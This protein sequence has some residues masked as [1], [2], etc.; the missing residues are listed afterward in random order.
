MKLE[1]FLKTGLRNRRIYEPGITLY[2][3]RS[4]RSGID[5]D[6]ATMDADEPGQGALTRF[7]DKYEKR[8]SFFVE[9]IHNPRLASY[10][11]RRGYFRVPYTHDVHMVNRESVYLAYRDAY[12]KMLRTITGR[13]APSLLEEF[14]SR[15]RL[16]G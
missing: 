16:G 11:E 2:I 13:A 14:A 8:F 5:I 4:I 6:L 3:R 1:E 9:C 15:P 10:L 12:A 7:L